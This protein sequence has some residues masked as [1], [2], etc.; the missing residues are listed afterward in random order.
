MSEP[1]AMLVDGEP[2]PA[3]MDWAL[4]R[5]LHYGDGLFET[6]LVQDGH[7]RFEALHRA[8]LAEGCQRLHIAI[9]PELP[10][11]QARLLARRHP[12]CTLK[13]LVSRGSATARGY[14]PVGDEQPRVI[15]LAY[16]PP[17]AR[18]FPDR[19]RVVTLRSVLGENPQLAG[20]KHCNRLE[21]VLGRR[22]LQG[23]DAF[24]GLMA[25]S[26][27]LLVSGTMSNV[28]LE[29]DGE[30]MTPALDRCG[31]AGVMRAVVLREAA[32][33]GVPV[34]QHELPLPWLARC[35]GL[36]LTNAR[37]GVRV[38]H[39]LDGRRLQDAP[40]LQPLL[41]RVTGLAR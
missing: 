35:T 17:A 18:E 34:R 5:A 6:L 37:M 21:Q 39:E 22:E 11:Q 15:V 14:T 24:E 33:C 30:W 23:Q 41:H 7:L 20:L 12:Q 26:S 2:A 19:L 40:A 25:S 10:W 8:R 16:P 38:V 29:L 31:V 36:F 32:S 13:L 4:D 3:A 1:L 27:G 28:F 9:D